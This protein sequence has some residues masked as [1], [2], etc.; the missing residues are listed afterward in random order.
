MSTTDGDI[1]TV[2]VPLSKVGLSP[3]YGSIIPIKDDKLLWVWGR[4]AAREP[5]NPVYGNISEDGGKNWS[6]Q[7][8]LKMKNGEELGGVFHTALVRLKSGVLGLTLTR[9][10]GHSWFHLSE[11][12]GQ[13]WSEGVAVTPEE[14][15]VF[16]TNDKA[17]V[18]SGGRIVLPAYSILEPKMLIP[19]PKREIRYGEEFGQAGTYSMGYCVVYY[20][21]D[22]G[23]TWK[24]SRNETYAMIDKGMGGSYT[25]GEP[26]IVELKDGRLLM[27]GRTNMGRFFV[28][29]SDDQGETWSETEPNSLVCIPSPCSL[30]RI[31][32]TGNLLVIWNQVS[33]FEAMCGL[34]RHRLSCAVSKDEGKTWENYKNL[35][36]LDD[37]T[38]IENAP[39][40]T[41]LLKGFRQPTDRKR[42]HR[43]PGPLRMSYPSCTFVEG[44]A[45]ISYGVST[46]GDKNFI[47]ETFGIKYDDLMKKWDFFPQDRGNRVRV[48]PVEWF[49][50]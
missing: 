44:N 6:D 23:K 28:S 45:V 21:D 49:Y 10:T 27:L 42:Y 16:N 29:Y 43:A 5:L 7:F 25:M 47:E 20:S 32:E 46:F 4:G 22:D 1:L 14:V 36:S 38:V 48:I 19:N 15:R 31:P 50:A 34:Y 18:L 9:N 12:E 17:L 3:S 40:E 24:R 39:I 26:S 33:H 11:D 35:E 2:N 37:T 41:V 8:A 30:E 13:T